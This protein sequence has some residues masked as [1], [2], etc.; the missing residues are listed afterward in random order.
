MN[1]FLCCFIIYYYYSHIILVLIQD[2]YSAGTSEIAIARLPLAVY[3][4]LTT[5][6]TTNRWVNQTRRHE[7]PHRIYI[8]FRRR[9]NGYYGRLL[10]PPE[11]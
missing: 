11:Y 2:W 3:R 1:L 7:C 6:P 5:A 4:P 10:S 8:A 9:G